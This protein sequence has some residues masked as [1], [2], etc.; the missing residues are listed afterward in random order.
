MRRST[1]R[2]DY[3]SVALDVDDS[4]GMRKS[5]GDTLSRRLSYSSAANSTAGKLKRRSQL[6]R[7][8]ID[9]PNLKGE[10]KRGR[11]HLRDTGFANMWLPSLN[12]LNTK[13]LLGI[14]L[15]L[16]GITLL[17]LCL[18]G[19]KYNS[20]RNIYFARMYSREG[21]PGEARFGIRG[22]CLTESISPPQCQPSTDFVYV[23]WDIKTSQY[24]N[25]TFP[26]WFNDAVTP[27]QDTDP[28]SAPTP[29]H[30]V[31]LTASL[32]ISTGCA[33]IAVLLQLARSIKGLHYRDMYYTRAFIMA[34]ATVHALLSM[35]L[36]LL[37]YINGC[38]ELEAVYPHL[39]TRKG[40]CLAMIGTAFGTF[41]VAAVLFFHNFL[42]PAT[43]GQYY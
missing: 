31:N 27:D 40:P 41:L 4:N 5:S 24:L 15:A 1:S 39:Q 26:A 18:I 6:Y 30:D 34:F 21:T 22:Y 38:Q 29:P 25:T 32:S 17:I 33:I 28:L 19:A 2:D 37:I 3:D 43:E 13:D 42:S 12:N 10:R 35:A 23:P 7:K 11:R 8:S 14:A 9:S 36:S 20:V 16:C